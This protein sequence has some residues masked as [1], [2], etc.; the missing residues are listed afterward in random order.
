[1][2]FTN[3]YNDNNYAVSYSELEFPNCYYLA[4]MDLPEI[5]SKHS[6]KGSAVDFGCG[7]GRSSRFLKSLGFDVTGIDISENM[8]GKA[9]ELDPQGKYVCIPDGDFSALPKRSFN[10]VQS[11]FAFDNI[12]GEE[13]RI[14]LFR[15][16]S[17][18]LVDDGVIVCLDA[19]P[20][21]YTN[22]WSSFSTKDFPENK[23]AAS[24]S[25]VKV[26]NLDL[27]D[28]RPCEDIFWKD[29]D[30][31]KQF[32]EAGLK[33]IA[34]YKPLARGTEPFAW[35]N[36]TKIAPWIIYVLKKKSI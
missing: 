31:Q 1:M 4:Y 10:L 26:I 8:I 30:Y 25:V 14:K 32:S 5:I 6:K 34:S 17:E 3:A 35:I 7:A 29:E 11:V 18:L 20:E 21:L 19:T 15:N 28:R 36:E 16:L 24:G 23:N 22:E 33:I 9:Q 2:I 27:G 12:P 13:K